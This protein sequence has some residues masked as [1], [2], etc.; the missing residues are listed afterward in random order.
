M[1]PQE[2]AAVKFVHSRAV[3]A[4]SL[5]PKTSIADG[6]SG[7]RRMAKKWSSLHRPAGKDCLI[8]AAVMRLTG[9]KK[10][11]CRSKEHRLLHE[12][13]DTSS[14]KMLHRYLC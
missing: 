1:Q 7:D 11:K 5:A 6:R 3:E 10:P 9:G 12:D 4:I 13:F 2:V 8:I 14:K